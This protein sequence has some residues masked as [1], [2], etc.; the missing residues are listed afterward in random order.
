MK[1]SILGFGTIGSGVYEIAKANGIEIEKVLDL[2][3]L[4]VPELTKDFNEVLAGDCNT[5]VETM[6]GEHPAYEFVKQ[7]L[8]KGKSVVTSNKALV[9]AFGED[10]IATA[11]AH[12]VR[13]LFEASVGGGIPIIHVITE[14][15]RCDEI[16]RVSGILNGTTNFILEQMDKKGMSF[17]EA[18]ALAQKLGYAEKDPSAD[19]EG[20][21]TCRK[22]AILGWLIS[23]KM[24]DYKAIPTE[25]ITKI[26]IEDIREAQSKGKV[27]KLL[28]VVEKD[29]YGNLT[30]HVGPAV[31]GP[32]NELYSVN[33]VMN[34]VL[35]ESEYMGRSMYYGPGAG[36]LPTATAVIA[37]VMRT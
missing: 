36:K 27:I 2:R 23:G 22:T 32:E 34:A 11:E 35:V 18:L 21:D 33:G 19:I 9:A 12:N 25:G 13:F 24:P 28:G 6:G 8:E 5:V 37:D 26:T 17:D 7:C 20:W 30:A 15:L 4:E 29:S 3:D 1:I 31:I 14:C 10:L 16:T